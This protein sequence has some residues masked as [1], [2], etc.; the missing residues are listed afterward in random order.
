MSLN[1]QIFAQECKEDVGEE[2]AV[3]ATLARLGQAGKGKPL[4][5]ES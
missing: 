3:E 4:G 5:A 2:G 1:A